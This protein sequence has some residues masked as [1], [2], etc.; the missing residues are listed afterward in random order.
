MITLLIAQY[1]IYQRKKKFLVMVKNFLVKYE[2]E[3]MFSFI[4]RL[5]NSERKPYPI[6]LVIS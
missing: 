3:M 2:D 5:V 1:T 4:R 6:E